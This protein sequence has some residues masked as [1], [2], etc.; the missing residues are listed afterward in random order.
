M[1][2]PSGVNVTD[3][4]DATEISEAWAEV[5]YGHDT[6]YDYGPHDAVPRSARW[7]TEAAADRSYH[8][9][10]GAGDE[11]NSWAGH[12]TWSTVDVTAGDDADDPADTAVPAYRALFV[13][14]ASQGRGSWTGAGPRAN[15]HLELTRAGGGRPWHLSEVTTAQAAAPSA[16]SASSAPSTSSWPSTSTSMM[17]SAPSP[18]PSLSSSSS[19]TTPS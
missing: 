2:S 19:S 12:R 18:P 14:G 17:S 4:T 11:W 15:V 13:E 7:Y 8:P 5:A 1:P 10:S 9:A 3:G 6:K 16:Q